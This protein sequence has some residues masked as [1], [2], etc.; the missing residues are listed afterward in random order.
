MK[1]K[2]ENMRDLVSKLKN[3]FTK[4][5]YNFRLYVVNSSCWEENGDE[6]H[7]IAAIGSFADSVVRNTNITQ[8]Q[9]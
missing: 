8:T 6:Y 7:I 5:N 9:K 2:L 3:D 1:S 4:S